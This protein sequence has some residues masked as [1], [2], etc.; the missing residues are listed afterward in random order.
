MRMIR[1]AKGWSKNE[2][3][4]DQC[5][6]WLVI[7]L[8]L[9]GLL[10]LYSTSSYI[11]QQRYGDPIY[12]LK[13][14]T[15]AT[16]LGLFGMLIV[17]NLPLEQWHRL[18]GWPLLFA[19][20]SC[21]YVI[22]NGVQIN[23]ARR[24]IRLGPVTVQ[25]SEFAK[26]AVIL[27]LA[28]LIERKPQ[29]MKDLGYLCRLF[30]C[31]VPVM[32]AILYNN[33]ST[34][35]ILGGIAVAML[36]A[37]SPKIW[38]FVLGGAIALGAGAG[39]LFFLSTSY[40]GERIQAWLDPA[41][42]A[43]GYQILQG[44][45]AIGSGGLFGRGLGKSMQKLGFLPEPQN[46]MVFSIVCEEFG[47]VGA[48][49]LILLFVLLLWRLMVIATRTRELYAAMIVTGILAH[50]AIQVILNIAVVTNSIPN[51]GIT[52]PFVSYGGTSVIFLLA[53][54]GLALNVSQKI[55]RK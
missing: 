44:L 31:I 51:T 25:P 54:M 16:A 26:L 23:G 11:G 49:F 14:Q 53:E 38:Y 42:H 50:L 47:F 22:F 6:L 5:L 32:G 4:Y 15:V 13:K 7:A 8:V 46:D 27:T 34:A 19:F 55:T 2:T 30:A 33:L 48:V 17:S 39:I 29:R 18:K 10:M 52:L 21:I 40:R 1:P 9:F 45:Y 20:A 36:F 12:F 28:Y 35:V 24:W 37:A 3:S 43:K 41:H